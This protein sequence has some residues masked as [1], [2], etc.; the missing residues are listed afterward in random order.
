[1]KN[2]KKATKNSEKA[3][4]LDSNEQG[5]AVAHIEKT[6]ICQ[7]E[8]MES[9]DIGFQ[10]KAEVTKGNEKYEK[11]L[12]EASIKKLHKD[13]EKVELHAFINLPSEEDSNCFEE[14]IEER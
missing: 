13:E 8:E 9:P 10:S 14:N 7:K 2:K 3:E 11:V 12:P 4:N 6:G 5:L 1:M